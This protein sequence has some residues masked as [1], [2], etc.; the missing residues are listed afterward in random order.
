MRDRHSTSSFPERF[1]WGA[2]TSAF[3]IEGATRVDGRGESIWDRFCQ[4]DGAIEDGSDGVVA[5]DHYHRWASDLDL[6]QSLGLGAYRFSVAWPRILPEGRGAVN[7]GGLDFY[8]RLVDGL[9]ERGITPWI[10]L[11]HWDLPQPLEDRG[12][13]PARHTVDAFLEYTDVVTRRLGDRVRHWITINE[14]WIIANL[15]YGTG[16]HAPGRRDAAAALAA[17]H[18][19]LLAHGRAMSA[20]RA[21]VPRAEAGITLNLTPAY[22]ES[23]A[24]AD[25]AAAN[26]FDA[27]F[28]RWYLDPL[29]RGSYPADA[30]AYHRSCLGGADPLAAVKPGDMDEIATSTDFLGINY[31]SRAILAHGVDDDGVTTPRA[32]PPTGPVTDMGW[33]VYAPGLSDLLVRLSRDYAPSAL[34]ITENGAAY[35]SAPE[36]A[37]AIEDDERIDYL[38]T[39]LEACLAALEQGVPL[40]GYFAWSLL[41]NFEWAFGYTKRFGIT[42]VDY[43]T[44]ERIPKNSAYWYREVV[45]RNGFG[46]EEAAE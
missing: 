26:L 35:P 44:Q 43:A 18:H 13:W 39:H 21:N 11:Y 23:A 29:Y 25:R 22:P 12:G 41:D 45:R 19:L 6:L 16:V 31:Y 40:A 10:T 46:E 24:A 27:F 33:E 34:Y 4:R 17:G 42:W 20:I 8:A 28:N 30:I 36:T 14:P 1:V 5:C 2:A 38:R 15:G 3:Q 9:L 7:E 37:G 32:A